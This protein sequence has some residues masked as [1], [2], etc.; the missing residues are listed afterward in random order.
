MRRRTQ[1]YRIK[2]ALR[3]LWLRS[4]ERNEALRRD[5]YTCQKC[6]VKKSQA[7]GKEQ[8]VEV[9]HKHGINV[10]EKIIKLIQDELLCDPEN[11]E[12]LCPRCHHAA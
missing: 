9:H 1:K 5:N 11:L 10:W 2:S 12:T 8:K 4:S 3:L 7:K 6:G